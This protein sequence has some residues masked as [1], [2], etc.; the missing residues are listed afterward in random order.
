MARPHRALVDL[1]AGRPLGVVDD[2]DELRRSAL[3]HRMGGLLW[4]AVREQ[5]RGPSQWREQLAGADLVARA[6]H[7]RLWRNLV[8]LSESL[9]ERGLHVATFKGVAAEH[10]WYARPGERPCAD[11]DLLLDP[12]QLERIDEVVE[13]IEPGHRLRGHT[14]AL[15]AAD[16]LQS[17]ELRTADGTSIDLHVDVMKLWLPSRRDLMWER[18]VSVEA[19]IGGLVRALDAEASL[20]QFLVHLTKDRFRFLLGYADVVRVLGDPDLDHDFVAWWAEGE[21]LDLHYRRALA[22]VAET[23]GL[24]IPVVVPGTVRAHVW[25]VVWRPDIRLRGEEG[26]VRF[27]QRQLWVT[28]LAR[29]PSVA[30]VRFLARKLVPSTT[31]VTYRRPGRAPYAWK[32]TGAR[33]MDAVRRWRMARHLR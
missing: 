19:P 15:V 16:R 14:G 11:I 23:S 8:Q 28:L 6:H 30:K 33:A 26:L 1:A 27:R 18:T 4:S 13:T 29:G 5:D 7:Q 31:L 20:L 32:I 10:R 25:A 24:D 12:G 17:V 3:E 22:T 9:E 21:G 2:H